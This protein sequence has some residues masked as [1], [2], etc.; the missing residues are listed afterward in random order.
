[1]DREGVYAVRQIAVFDTTL[2]D[3]NQAEGIA[4]SINDK[5]RI[6]ER[7]D[8]LGVAYVEGG[9]P[10]DTNPKDVGFFIEARKLK[11][12]HAKIAAFSSTLRAGNKPEDDPT[13]R[14]LLDAETAAVAIFGK[15]WSLHTE[16][17][18]R[19][20]LD[21]NL[22]MI[23]QS[24]RYLR[25]Q[26][27]EVIYDAEHFF[28]GYRDDPEYALRTLLAAE[29]GGADCL[30]LCD[31]NGGMLPD[32][33]MD[34]TR[35]VLE[36]VSTP[37]GVH[38][39]NDSGCGVAN[40]CV[41]V[42]IGATH[43]QGTMNGYGERCGNAD[44]SAI[45][46]NIE[47][48]LGLRCLPDGHL[49]QLHS[50][51]WFVSEVANQEHALRAPYVGGCA[52]SHKGGMHIDAV[53]KVARSFEHVEPEAVGNQRK[54]LISDQSGGSTVVEK[55]GRI[56]PGIKKQDPR[57][58]GLLK[59]LKELEN[60]GY[61]YEAAEGSFEL[62]ARRALG[63]SYEIFKLVGFRVTVDRAGPDEPA[64]SE[65]TVRV[66]VGDTE[67]H[68]ASEGNGPVD[69]LSKA[70]RKSLLSYYP[71]LANMKLI[72]YK[73][74]V[75]GSQDGTAARVRVLV[76]TADGDNS[77]GTVGVSSDIIEASWE[78]VVDSYVYGLFQ[79]A[80]WRPIP[81]EVGPELRVR[82]G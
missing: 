68:T 40:T 73:V 63:T 1:M 48:K 81:I 65:A 28:D 25:S 6:A 15:S 21:Q 9:W 34:M 2:R 54:L 16:R 30:V 67:M 58:T 22:E 42:A 12:K 33:V 72:D 14:F 44:L 27:R 70:L 31:T 82:A 51:S 29:E 66:R 78:A 7:L 61:Q 5:L 47:L 38:M 18:L 77:W 17:I 26:G 37:V 3:G 50:T 11:L 49:P 76:E 23:E 39:H 19:V 43:V 64:R 35:A 4:L 46:P 24:V 59:Q 20:T 10:N 53:R 60:Q 41:A 75:L 36:R 13:L 8:S 55:L 74:R 52:F 57:V 45:I 32:A 79:R 69:A 62:L 56:S 80:D 71:D